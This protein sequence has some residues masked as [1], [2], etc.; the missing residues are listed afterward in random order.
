MIAAV[1]PQVETV[2][3]RGGGHPPPFPEE[4]SETS[5]ASSS[6]SEFRRC[7]YAN[8]SLEYR[9]TGMPSF[10]LN[11]YRPLVGTE[12]GRAASEKEGIAPFVDGSIRREPDLEHE[13]PSISCLCRGKMF[14]PRLAAG[15]VVAYMTTKGKH[16]GLPKRHWRLTAVLEVVEV[17]PSHPAAA[18]WYVGRGLPLPSNCMVPGNEAKP[19][20][21]SD[22]NHRGLNSCLDAQSGCNGWD[23]QYRSRARR[24]STF[25]ICRPLFRELS[26]QAPIID[27]SLLTA[28]FGYLPGTRNPGKHDFDCFAKLT[29]SLRII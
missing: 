26:W 29:S 25:V 28:V 10:Y 15:D 22:R 8:W 6:A 27:E 16:G 3:E 18:A 12:S 17:L 11:T 2:V 21:Q 9:I 19:L 14:A 24:W 20:S 1:Q 4:A 7:L 5:G 13:F 23:E